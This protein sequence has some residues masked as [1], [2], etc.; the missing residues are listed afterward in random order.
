MSPHQHPGPQRTDGAKE[1]NH[2]AKR[3]QQIQFK[4]L[5]GLKQLYHNQKQL[6]ILKQ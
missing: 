1:G 6:L 5:A 3:K 2:T 4:H